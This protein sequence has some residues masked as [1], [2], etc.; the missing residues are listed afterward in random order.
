MITFPDVIMITSVIVA[1]LC[2]FTAWIWRGQFVAVNW[3]MFVVA[4]IG[5]LVRGWFYYQI[6]IAVVHG[7]SVDYLIPMSRYLAE[8]ALVVTGVMAI[9][10][11]CY[12]YTNLRLDT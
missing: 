1:L 11:L 6:N 9:G 2:L 8:F 3:L 10:A 5:A 4:A 7:R 12:Y